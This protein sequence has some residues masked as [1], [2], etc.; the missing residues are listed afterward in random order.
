M[1]RDFA[2]GQAIPQGAVANDAQIG[3]D[4]TSDDFIKEKLHSN[5]RVSNTDPIPAVF[6][7][8]DRFP[9]VIATILPGL[10]W[11]GSALVQ[12]REMITAFGSA[13][14]NVPATEVRPEPAQGPDFATPL[15]TASGKC[16]PG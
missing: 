10:V 4:D 14:R 5:I 11:L 7:P 3:R 9:A 6:V 2:L 1:G 15:D 12:L 13:S 16:V 8:I